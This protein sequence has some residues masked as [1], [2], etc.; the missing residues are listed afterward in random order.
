MCQVSLK[1]IGVPG[2]CRQVGKHSYISREEEELC[3]RLKDGK[4]ESDKH[5]FKFR[6]KVKVI[7]T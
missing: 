5:F 4:Y 1:Y 6:S 2:L 3:Q 7:V